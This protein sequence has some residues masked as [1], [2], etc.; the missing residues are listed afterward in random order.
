VTYI[1]DH[2]QRRLRDQWAKIVLL[3]LRNHGVIGSF[4][5]L[6]GA[7]S[8]G[9]AAS[10]AA[11]AAAGQG[12]GQGGVRG[13]PGVVVA[14]GMSMVGG[15]S[16]PPAERWASEHPAGPPPSHLPASPCLARMLPTLTMP[17]AG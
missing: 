2:I 15:R 16:W 11:S 12:Q 1:L 7:L 6:T 3:L 4:S 5:K 17:H 14:G 10:S 9:L 8:Q 13:V